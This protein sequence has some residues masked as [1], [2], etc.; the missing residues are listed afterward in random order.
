MAVGERSRHVAEQNQS[1]AQ[2]PCHLGKSLRDLGAMGLHL[3]PLLAHRHRLSK[4]GE[5]TREIAGGELRAT[6]LFITDDGDPG[7][8]WIL[9]RDRF[10]NRHRFA[11]RREGPG[12]VP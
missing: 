6:D 1:R 10:T 3:Q 4:I 2:S 7:E 8:R 9:R 12:G 11:I 5:R